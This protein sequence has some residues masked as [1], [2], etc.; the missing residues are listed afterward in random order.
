MSSFVISEVSFRVEVFA[1]MLTPVRFHACMDAHMYYKVAFFSKVFVA[2][3]TAVLFDFLMSGEHVLLDIFLPS[4]SL[5]TD[6][7]VIQSGLT[8]LL[9]GC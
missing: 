7:A 3:E 9:C 6:W 4:Q 2:N 1:T 5:Q 8:C